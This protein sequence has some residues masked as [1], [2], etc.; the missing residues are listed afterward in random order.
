[1]RD[2]KFGDVININSEYIIILGYY[3]VDIIEKNFY[4]YL[5]HINYLRNVLVGIHVYDY[6]NLRPDLVDIDTFT[7]DV[8]NNIIVENISKDLT[9]FLIKLKLVEAQIPEYYTKEEVN[10]YTNKI[11]KNLRQK[12]RKYI[13]AKLGDIYK[14]HGD[15]NK[16]VYLG[17]N[18]NLKDLKTSVIPSYFNHVKVLDTSKGVITSIMLISIERFVS[19]V[20][21]VGHVSNEEFLNLINVEKLD[22]GQEYLD[23]ESIKRLC[24]ASMIMV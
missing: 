21:K 20:V 16:Y 3:Y 19:N 2:L 7:I 4:S 14:F 1:M 12:Y 23:Y 6:K 9:K 17:M 10:Q 15:S 24:K 11:I 13:N 5:H 18:G 8:D 22:Y